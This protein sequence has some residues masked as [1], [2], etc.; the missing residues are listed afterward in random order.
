MGK[1]VDLTGQKYG[2]LT[3][4]SRSPEI[5]YK[6][7]WNCS[8]ECGG[9]IVARGN[10]LRNGGTS[11]CG[12]LQKESRVASNIK[13]GH[14]TFRAGSTR[15]YNSWANM[16]QR[17]TNPLNPKWP[18]YGARGIRVCDAW[19]DFEAFYRDMGDRPERTSIDRIDVDGNYEP[20]NCRWADARTQRLNQR[21][22][23]A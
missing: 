20:G 6:I 13:H 19:H 12:C 11:S 10:D 18:I 3:V 8:C 14:A 23:A 17:C 7:K 21:R 16:M 2:R 1:F 15:T 9:S 4:L 22:K 5:G